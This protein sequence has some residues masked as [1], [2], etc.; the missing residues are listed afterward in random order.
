MKLNEFSAWY[1]DN[2]LEESFWVWLLL[3]FIVFF[4]TIKEIRKDR[5]N[6]QPSIYDFSNQSLEEYE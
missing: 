6:S 5:Q 1:L 4:I 2:Y 3:A